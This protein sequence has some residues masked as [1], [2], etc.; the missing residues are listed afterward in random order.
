M[1]PSNSA[2]AHYRQVR[3]AEAEAGADPHRAIQLLLAGV[4]ERLRHASAC[5]ERGDVPGKAQAISRSLDIVQGLRLALDHDAGGSIAAG[6]ESLYVYAETE[7]VRANANNDAASLRDIAGL[8]D[9]IHTAW[10]AI[11]SQLAAARQQQAV[12]A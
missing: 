4:I 1:H 12:P 10:Q 8:F 9:E 2:L 11:P 6:L 7:L 5:I 3:S